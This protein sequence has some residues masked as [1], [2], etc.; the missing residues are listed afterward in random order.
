MRMYYSIM[1]G[2]LGY[3]IHDV[4]PDLIYN[5]SLYIFLLTLITEV[6]NI[7][8]NTVYTNIH[9]KDSQSPPVKGMADI[10]SLLCLWHFVAN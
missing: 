9:R 7:T 8:I 6:V 5:T 1:S 4:K 2:I 3:V 10:V